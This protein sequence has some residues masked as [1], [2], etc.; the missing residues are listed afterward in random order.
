[1]QYSRKKLFFEN[2]LAYGMMSVL[3][4][5]VP[6]IMLPVV[7][8]LITDTADYGRVEMFNTIVGFGTGFA[9]L[10]MYD[11]MFREYFEKDDSHYKN[12]VTSTAAC[13]FFV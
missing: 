11:A 5:I 1:M 8:R 12:V 3:D 4:K 6:F 7:T 13:A 9:V 2:F 10:G